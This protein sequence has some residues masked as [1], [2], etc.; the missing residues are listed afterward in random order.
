MSLVSICGCHRLFAQ[1]TP[2]NPS[3]RDIEEHIHDR[4]SE[5]RKQRETDRRERRERAGTG[6]MGS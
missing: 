2:S 4:A 3:A 1:N 6:K 5:R